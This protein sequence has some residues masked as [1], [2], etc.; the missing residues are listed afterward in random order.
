MSAAVAGGGP[1]ATREPVEDAPA[2][3]V[4]ARVPGLGSA[5]FMARMSSL[6]D[7]MNQGNV[8]RAP[9]P[10]N[11]GEVGGVVVGLPPPAAAEVPEGLVD[12]RIAGP[13]DAPHG[14]QGDGDVGG[15]ADAPEEKSVAVS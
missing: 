10:G 5:E 2:S 7:W 14:E 1:V 8:S 3:P 4:H 11:D 15:G 6:S 12:E 9:R 13:R